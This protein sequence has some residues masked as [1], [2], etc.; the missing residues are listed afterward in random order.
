MLISEK[1][2]N[3]IK[4]ANSI[5]VISHIGPDGDTLGSSFALYNMLKQIGPEKKIDTIVTG[6]MP[7]IYKFMPGSTE[8]KTT[9]DEGLYQNYDLAISVDCAA[10]DRLGDALTLFKNAKA[11]LCIDHHISNPAFADFN[12]IDHHASATGEIIFDILKELKLTLTKEIATDIYAAIL[13]DTGGF[14]FDNTTPKTFLTASELLA[15]GIDIKAIYKRCY[16]SKPIN[17]IKLQAAALHNSKFISN[18]RIAYTCVDKKMMKEYNATDDYLDGISET[19][20][21]V[22]TVEVAMVLKQTIKGDTKISFRSN[23]VDVSKIAEFF[24][25]G[26]HKLAAGCTV[27]KNIEETVRELL[28]IVLKQVN[29]KNEKD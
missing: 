27:Q 12:I 10:L 8:A 21:Q 6:K 1:L 2:K 22:D 25:G 4:D 14:K 23:S 11:T 9:K 15:S 19:L 5:V 29:L 3:V 20:R 18:N 24:G 13:T 7:E 28:P 16:D 17:M 26:G